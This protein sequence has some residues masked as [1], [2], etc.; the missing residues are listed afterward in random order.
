MGPF[1]RSKRGY[2]YLLVFQDLFS[3]WIELA[4]LKAAN[5]ENILNS[6]LELVITRWGTPQ[7]LHS[8]SGTEFNNKTVRELSAAFGI[9][10]SFNPLYHPQANPVERTNRV[11]KTMIQS[12]IEQDHRNWDAHLN[13]FRFT[14]NT[15]LHG[16]NRVTPAFLNMGREPLPRN[17]FRSLK[18]GEVELPAVNL[19]IWTTRMNRMNHLRDM[20]TIYQDQAFIKKA[21]YY[22]QRRRNEQFKVGDLVKKTNHVLSRARDN[23]AEK[24]APKFSGPFVVVEVIAP[25]VYK[26]ASQEGQLAGRYH[27]SHLQRYIEDPE[28][29]PDDPEEQE[30]Q[31]QLNR[32]LLEIHNSDSENGDNDEEAAHDPDINFNW[33]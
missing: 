32:E 26:L 6:F 19:S 20:I 10:R 30:R 31:A 11:L 13:E 7:V 17:S 8:D 3:K 15:S 9:H 1:P 24:L 4:P 29:D 16:T 18:E 22:D 12:F 21:K 25:N 5:S 23:V 33:D 27:A 28:E 2:E 14:Y